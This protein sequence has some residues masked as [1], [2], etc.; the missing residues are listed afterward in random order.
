VGFIPSELFPSAEPCTL[1]LPCP[2][3]VFDIASSCSEDQKVTMP[4]NFRAL[5][6]AEIRTRLER[7]A[8]GPI[9]SWDFVL[10][11]SRSPRCERQW[12]GTHPV[13]HGRRSPKASRS[14]EQSHV[15]S[16]KTGFHR[17]DQHPKSVHQDLS[18]GSPGDSGDSQIAPTSSEQ[19]SLVSPTR[20]AW[21]GRTGTR[22]NPED[23]L[24][25]TRLRH[26]HA[27]GRPPRQ[28]F[29]SHRFVKE[30]L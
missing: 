27:A 7:T 15:S 12:P 28:P 13:A 26:S 14:G 25:R 24:L 23:G 18:P 5:L 20:L 19:A 22:R 29:S 4:R 21:P 11:F 6:P 8:R 2:P 30:N 17:S 9:L 3:V 1:R 16:R 10:S